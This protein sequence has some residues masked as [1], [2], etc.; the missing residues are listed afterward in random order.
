MCTNIILIAIIEDED[1]GCSKA[2]VVIEVI[3]GCDRQQEGISSI[4]KFFFFYYDFLFDEC[5]YLT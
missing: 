3:G 5:G 1:H 4:D 2:G